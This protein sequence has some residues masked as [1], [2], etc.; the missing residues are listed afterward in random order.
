MNF[1]IGDIGGKKATMCVESIEK[2]IA[3]R[4]LFSKQ[5]EHEYDWDEVFEKQ[6]IPFIKRLAASGGER[7]ASEDVDYDELAFKIYERQ[8]DNAITIT[9]E[10]NLL[11][12]HEMRTKYDVEEVDVGGA[13]AVNTLGKFLKKTTQ[14]CVQCDEN[15]ESIHNT[16]SNNMLI[17]HDDLSLHKMIKNCR[18]KQNLNIFICLKKKVCKISSFCLHLAACR[19]S[20]SL[21][22]DFSG[23][24]L[25]V[26]VADFTL[27][28]IVLR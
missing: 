13:L 10:T 19:V 3:A 11:N 21:L 5:D 23:N 15:C 24:F 2:N 6:F 14:N 9:K 18:K 7:A 17:V 27:F 12:Y 22:S 20:V 8:C 4:I 28:R 25:D 26:C 1:K 16:S